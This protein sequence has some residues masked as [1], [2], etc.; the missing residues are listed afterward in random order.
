MSD[1]PLASVPTA[2][3]AAAE[4]QET[5][6]SSADAPRA[7]T[8]IICGSHR[9]PFHCSAIAPAGSVPTAIQVC[10]GHET[11]HRKLYLGAG[12][13]CNDHD[14]ARAS[15]DSANRVAWTPLA[16]YVTPDLTGV[17]H[18]TPG[19]HTNART[20]ARITAT[21]EH[22]RLRDDN[23]T[24]ARPRPLTRS[25]PRQGRCDTST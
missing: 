2:V 13:V 1:P 3:Q 16:E 17:A 4:L 21:D 20:T 19:T 8:G 22:T 11:S 7:F 24:R 5:D 9:L 25:Q 14:E 15:S 6:W 18:A 23:P 10:D 12:V